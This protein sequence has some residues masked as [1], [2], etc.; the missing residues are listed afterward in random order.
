MPVRDLEAI[1]LFARSDEEEGIYACIF[2]F[3]VFEEAARI[4]CPNE[5]LMQKPSG[6][7]K[8]RGCCIEP[9]A[10]QKLAAQNSGWLLHQVRLSSSD[11]LKGEQKHSRG[12]GLISDAHCQTGLAMMPL[13]E[14][15]ALV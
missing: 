12:P 10:A 13:V 6:M 2:L 3:K 14:P 5:S 9:H 8:Y 11:T 1:L 7:T 15:S 4:Y